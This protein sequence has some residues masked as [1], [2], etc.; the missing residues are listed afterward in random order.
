MKEALQALL[1]RNQPLPGVGA[2][3]ARLADRTYMTHCYGDWFAPAQVEQALSRLVL[4]AD[5]FGHR[6]LGYAGLA[7]IVLAFLLRFL[8]RRAAG[9]A[10]APPVPPVE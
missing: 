6:W 5:N 10:A 8:Q 3:S 7:I 1:D 9:K 2:C 4:A